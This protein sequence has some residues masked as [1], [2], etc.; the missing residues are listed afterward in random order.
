[1]WLAFKCHV[2]LPLREGYLLAD[3]LQT[4]MRDGEDSQMTPRISA[5]QLLF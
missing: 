4:A 1:M 2:Q 5:P 3:V